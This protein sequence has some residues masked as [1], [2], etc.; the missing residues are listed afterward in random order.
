MLKI[1]P[2][3]EKHVAPFTQWFNALPENNVWNEAYVRSKTVADETYSPE[4]MIAAE[5]DG[6][7]VGFVLGSKDNEAGWIKAFL[8]RA[9]RQRQGIGTAMFD[10]IEDEFVRQGVQGINA[11]WAPPR[12]FIPGVNVKYTSAIVFLDRRGYE[13]NRN[14]R[15]NM[16]VA[17]AGRDFDTAEREAF[18]RTRGLIVRRAVPA[19]KPG[20]A[21]LCQEYDNP[22]WAIETGIALENPQPTVFVA[23]Q[24]GRIS[25]FAAH[26]VVGPT[27][28]GPML[29]SPELRGLGI[30]SVLLKRCL[31]DWQRAGHTRGEIIWTGPISFYARAVAA[32]MG[33]AFWVFY[34]SLIQ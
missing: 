33:S 31:V 16:D 29:T 5:E 34:K 2:F 11:G 26:S 24:E 9:D 4:L 1:V 21:R 28:F 20:L 12:Y 6:E 32:T 27:H 25:A 30:G 23:E 17:L 10:A 19:D 13:T 22:G 15:V 8:V 3:V 14:A 18:L 7:P